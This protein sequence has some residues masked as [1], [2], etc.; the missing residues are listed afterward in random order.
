L[1]FPTGPSDDLSNPLRR[2]LRIPVWSGLVIACAIPVCHPFPHVPLKVLHPFRAGA[3]GVAPDGLQGSTISPLVEIVRELARGLG[4]A[5]GEAAPGRPPRGAFPFSLGR[6]ALAR[7]GT[8]RIRVK[9][10]DV[11]HRMLL[12]DIG[13][14]VS[15]PEGQRLIPWMRRNAVTGRLDQFQIPTL[16]HLLAAHV[17][18]LE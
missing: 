14:V 6:Q 3:L 4:I 11:Y 5:P 8:V 15:L 2:T 7:P 9:P 18:V 13:Y 17:K 1:R 10:V 12:K 16:V